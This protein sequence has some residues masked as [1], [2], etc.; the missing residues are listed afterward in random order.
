MGIDAEAEIGGA[1]PVALVVA[2][3]AGPGR[4]RAREIGDLVL[5]EAGFGEGF[6]GPEIPIGDRVVVRQ[7]GRAEAEATAQGL[8]PEARIFVEL[9]HID[10]GVVDRSV[11]QGLN[12]AGP[13]TAGLAGQAGDEVGR[14][15]GDAGGAHP[16]ELG[17][18]F[19]AGVGAGGGAGFA[20]HKGLHAEGDAIDARALGGFQSRGGKLERGSFQGDF[21]VGLDYELLPDGGEKLRKKLGRKQRRGA[22]AQIDSVDLLGEMEA[23]PGGP[24]ARCGKLAA[25]GG[26]VGRH[27]GGGIN[28]RGKVAEGALGTAE[29]DRNVEA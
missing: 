14:N 6:A 23:L 28:P 7:Q 27:G 11:R 17:Q 24:G 25:Q 4:T 13:A 8:G 12:G 1:E 22:A 16:F 19:C 5:G 20:V 15:M 10:T 26:D 29:R 2:G 3:P 9:E 21:G 18:G